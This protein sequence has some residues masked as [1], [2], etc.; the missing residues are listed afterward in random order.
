M[1]DKEE[2]IRLDNISKT[3]QMGNSQIKAVSDASLIIR[4]GGVL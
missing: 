3:Y 1:K 2:I 4:K